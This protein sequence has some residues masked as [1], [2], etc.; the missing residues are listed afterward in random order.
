MSDILETALDAI[1]TN[2]LRS[3]LTILI[4]TVGITSLVGIQTAIEILSNELN[5]SFGRMGAARMEITAAEKAPPDG[6]GADAC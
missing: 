4:I 2:R 1:R 6:P 5:D 3:I